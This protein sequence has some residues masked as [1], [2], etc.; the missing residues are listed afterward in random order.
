MS[1]GLW[2]WLAI[3]VLIAG[4]LLVFAWFLGEAFRLVRTLDEPDERPAQPADY[5]PSG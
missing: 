3:G 5:R 1:I 2:T 4:P